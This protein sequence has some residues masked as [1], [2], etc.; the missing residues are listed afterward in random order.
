MIGDP[1]LRKVVGADALGAIAAADLQLARVRLLR[2]LLLAAPPPSSRADSSA[3][4]ARAVLVL[5]ALVL[6]FDHDAGRQVGDAHGRIG[7]VDVLAAGAGGAVGVDAQVRRVDLDFL[8]LLELRQDRHRDGRGV[9]AALRFGGRHALHAVRAGL[10]FQPRED[11]A[12]DD[13]AD[14]FPVAAVLARTFAERSR[15]ASPALRR[16][17]STCA[18]GRRRRWPPR[19]PRCRRGSRGKC[20]ARRAGRAAAAG[21]AVRCVALLQG[22]HAG[23]RSPPRRGRACRNRRRSKSPARRTDPAPA[24]DTLRTPSAVGCRRAYSTDKSRNCCEFPSTSGAASS[25]RSSSK[26]CSAFSSF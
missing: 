2:G 20:C 4:A 8:D 15:P 7:L 17:A 12:A 1:T 25:G 24:A 9:D 11:A 13:A 18:A 3:I 21:A 14:D 16:S 26:R 6:A 19:R 22:V 10:E 23:W 5:R